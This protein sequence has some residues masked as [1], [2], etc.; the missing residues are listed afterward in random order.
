MSLLFLGKNVGDK[1]TNYRRVFGT[2]TA[3]NAGGYVS[4]FQT[5]DLRQ[6][7]VKLGSCIIRVES[8]KR[9]QCKVSG[10]LKH[11]IVLFFK[12]S[13]RRECLRG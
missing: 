12:H 10:F 7:V 11:V 5:E 13:F 2:F 4:K 1:K 6:T 9:Y 3:Q 8:S